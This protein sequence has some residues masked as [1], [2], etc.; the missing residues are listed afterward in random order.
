MALWK[1]RSLSPEQKVEIVEA[2]SEMKSLQPEDSGSFLGLDDVSVTEVNSVTLTV[3]VSSL[4]FQ[5]CVWAC[6]CYNYMF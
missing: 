3:P 5:I 1:A 2:D 4:R 6:L